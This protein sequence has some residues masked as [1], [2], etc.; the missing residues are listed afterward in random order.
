MKFTYLLINTAIFAVPFFFSFEK[1]VAFYKKWKYFFPAMM[2][3]ALPFLIWDYFFTL[4]GVWGFNEKYL[5]GIYIFNLPMEEVLFFITVPYAC[6][7]TY[8]VIKRYFTFHWNVKYVFI[9]LMAILGVFSVSFG[10]L[11]YTTITFLSLALLIALNICIIKAKH[12]HY[13]F[14]A[15]IVCLAGFL[16]FNGMLTSLPVVIYN[17][18]EN[19]AVRIFTIPVED[20]AYYM[21]LFLLNFNLYEY[22]KKLY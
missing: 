22:F 5:T 1:K 8:E 10:F 17:N 19:L 9:I 14:T 3:A 7:F 21:L 13:F 12:I 16:I 20:T 11:L 4:H 2:T 6:M 15:Y 18:S